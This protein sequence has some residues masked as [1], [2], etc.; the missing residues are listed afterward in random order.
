[1]LP[2]GLERALLATAPGAAVKLSKV[3]SKMGTPSAITGINRATMVAPLRWVQMDITA[4]MKPRNME[5]ESPEEDLGRVEVEEEKADEGAAPGQAVSRHNST[6]LID[7]GHTEQHHRGEQAPCPRPGHPSPSIRLSALTMPTIQITVSG[8]ENTPKLESRV[9]RGCRG[10]RCESR[11]STCRRRP[12]SSGR[13]TSA[14]RL[15][16]FR[17]RRRPRA[18]R[19]PRRRGRRAL[20]KVAV[21]VEQEGDPVGVDAPD[22]G[23]GAQKTR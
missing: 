2:V 1:M 10:V 19:W 8:S 4:K 21:G 17:S 12:R 23:H 5:P 14:W 16:P 7:E 22:P 13:S 9:R 18:T 6:A 15:A 20:T 3:V 11:R